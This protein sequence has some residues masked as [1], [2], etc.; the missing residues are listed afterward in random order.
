MPRCKKHDV[1][2]LICGCTTKDLMGKMPNLALEIKQK[3]AWIDR[4][5][6]ANERLHAEVNVLKA[7]VN[8]SGRE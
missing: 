3:D 2:T 5:L 8:N 4:L 6:K 7:K 1:G